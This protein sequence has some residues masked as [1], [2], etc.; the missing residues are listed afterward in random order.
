MSMEE[1]IKQITD[2]EFSK[3]MNKPTVNLKIESLKLEINKLSEKI[4]EQLLDGKSVEIKRNKDNTIK[5]Q[6]VVKK[7][8][9]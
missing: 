6:I 9:K 8:M 3:C 4:A 1:V 2:D 5:C 7:Q